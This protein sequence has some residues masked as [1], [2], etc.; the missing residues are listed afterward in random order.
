MVVLKA[1]GYGSDA[2]ILAN[3][4]KDEVHYLAVA[5]A[6][7]G[8][9][10]RNA[11]IRLPIL[12]LHPQ[13]VNLQK[14]I[15]FDL[16]PSIYASH[17]LEAFLDLAE[18]NNLKKYPIHLK[19]N[20]GLNRLGF[21]YKE[22]NAH[23]S[24]LKASNN[25]KIQSVFS[26]LAA[27]EDLNEKKFTQDQIDNFIS[28]SNDL[29]HQLDGKPPMRHMLNTSGIINYAARAQFD[30]VRLGIG[31]FGFGNDNYET[32]Q[33]ENVL[34]LKSIISQIHSIEKNQTVGYNRAFV[35]DKLM[36]TATIP[37]GHADGIFRNLGN[38]KGYVY[39]QNQKAPIIGNVC[40]DMIMVDVSSITCNEG[41]EVLI[42]KDKEHIIKLATAMN[43]IPYE[44]ITAIS[45]RIKRVIKKY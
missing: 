23:I 9:A 30:M 21:L 31:L 45:N 10:L 7:E 20:T 35:S 19:L 41:D 39:I 33:L 25:I 6:D 8:I 26:H 2:I 12:V 38:G 43:T 28:E 1:V 32:S 3:A 17:I 36:R 24:A 40:M 11:G 42:Y 27:S 16:E 37:I 34:C 5:Y 15:D 4:L 18:T 44:L 14:L 29:I 22:L 13:L